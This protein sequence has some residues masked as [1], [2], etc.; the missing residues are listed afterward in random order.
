MKIHLNNKLKPNE[1]N[2]N[3]QLNFTNTISSETVSNTEKEIRNHSTTPIQIQTYNQHIILKRVSQKKEIMS[4]IESTGN[5]SEKN[6]IKQFDIEESNK[7]INNKNSENENDRYIHV[8]DND[9]NLNNQT[10]PV[11]RD[12][13]GCEIKK[14]GK[15][16][17]SFADNAH[18]LQGRMKFIKEGY[19]GKVRNSVQLTTSNSD[20]KIRKG[21]RRSLIEN[22][23]QKYLKNFDLDDSKKKINKLVEVIEVQN[24][25]EF[26]KNENIYAPYDDNDDDDEEEEEGAKNINEETVCC[27]GSCNIY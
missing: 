16:R 5:N 9:N 26:N 11:R 6:I 22:K 13:F 12:I 21:L 23:N 27:S 14:G 2:K 7:N 17:V 1:N 25:K 10:I 24:Y 15:H 4:D 20:K 19:K 18:I 8:N 3:H